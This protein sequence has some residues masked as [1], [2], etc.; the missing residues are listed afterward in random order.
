VE[1]QVN[2]ELTLW[3]ALPT[4]MELLEWLKTPIRYQ[5]KN[6]LPGLVR[7]REAFWAA[8]PTAAF[9]YAEKRAFELSAVHFNVNAL[10]EED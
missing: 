8:S 4:A 1:Q 5:E 2:F 3:Y 10:V 9:H 7:A 6:P